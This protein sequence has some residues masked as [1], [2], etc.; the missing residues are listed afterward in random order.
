M[1]IGRYEI[2]DDYIVKNIISDEFPNGNGVFNPFEKEQIPLWG[3]Y[4]T[5]Y[6]GLNQSI[7]NYIMANT[8]NKILDQ[9][10]LYWVFWFCDG[11]LENIEELYFVGSEARSNAN[12]VQHIFN[13]LLEQNVSK[14]LDDLRN[15]LKE[16]GEI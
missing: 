2:G 15:Q 10:E 13:S 8:K 14:I 12:L 9:L 3:V 4:C 11:S 6:E 16:N 5:S 7:K 1:I